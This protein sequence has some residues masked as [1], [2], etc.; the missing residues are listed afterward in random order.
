MSDFTQDSEGFAGATL[1]QRARLVILPLIVAVL[2][3]VV[4]AGLTHNSRQDIRRETE[5]E[6][7]QGVDA[8][9]EGLQLFLDR[10]LLQV[11]AVAR[12]NDERAVLVGERGVIGPKESYLPI[13]VEVF[14]AE[15]DQVV[16]PARPKADPPTGVEGLAE[17]ARRRGVPVLSQP[18]RRAAAWYATVVAVRRV[19]FGADPGH[20]A[21]TFPLDD[22]LRWWTALELPAGM[23]GLLVHRRQHVW[24]SLPIREEAIGLPLANTAVGEALLGGVD[25]VGQLWQERPSGW[26]EAGPVAWRRLGALDL[27]VV[28]RTSQQ[29]MLSN[30]RGVYLEPLWMAGLAGVMITVVAFWISYSIRRDSELKARI[31]GQLMLS[32][33]RFRDMTDAAADW[34]YETDEDGRLTFVSRTEHQTLG[35]P[36]SHFIGRRLD[37][38]YGADTEAER[39]EALRAAMRRREAF[40]DVLATLP[41]TSGREMF[42]RVTGVPYENED[43]AF[44]GYRGTL[45]DVTP[46]IT[47]RREAEAAKQRLSRALESSGDGFIVYDQ[48]DRVVTWNPRF[49]DLLFPGREDLLRAGMGHD[50]VAEAFAEHGNFVSDMDAARWLSQRFAEPRG[51]DTTR[52]E[53]LCDGRW[54]LTTSRWTPE[55]YRISVYRDVTELKEREEQAELAN[56]TKTEFLAVTGHELRSPLNAIIGF[57]E[58]IEREYHGPVGDARYVEYAH[59][60]RGGGEH[61]LELI[62]DLLDISKAEAGKLELREDETDLDSVLRGALALIRHRAADAGL[63]LVVEDTER[64]PAVYADERKLKQV[65]LNLLTNAV[66]FTPEG[67]RIIVSTRRTPLGLEI[68]VADTGIGIAEADMPKVFAPFEQVDNAAQRVHKGTGLGVPLSKRLMEMH[69]GWLTLEST[70]GEGT[71]AR[72]GLPDSRVRD[73]AA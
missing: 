49:A 70:L 62:N 17:Q 6:L 35:L 25:R 14:T 3:A 27:A 45:T 32:E 69:G 57:A 59:D 36:E 30:W 44:Q 4:L 28:T 38:I 60:I 34:F 18:Y 22:L 50:A 48:D 13:E 43:G 39:L 20:V 67:G 47:A 68:A 58:L 73:E 31:H 12:L 8:A 40:R 1:R 37:E 10:L 42:V 61:L 71:T 16:L 46:R 29:A 56:K 72:M 66:K 54:V 53:K 41:L 51:A 19:E 52:L 33:A 23:E 26:F 55:N 24:M 64:L 15:G 11:D 2:S 65:L 21:L 5:I 9:A 63:D 7:R